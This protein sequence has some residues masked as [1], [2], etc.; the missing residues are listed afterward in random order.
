MMKQMQGGGKM[1]GGMDGMQQMPGGM[2]MQG[3]A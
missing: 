3:K 2:D 1:T